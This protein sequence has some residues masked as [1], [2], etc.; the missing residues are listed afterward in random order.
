[1]ETKRR[2]EFQLSR[3][4]SALTR[5]AADEFGDCARCGEPI[6]LKRLMFDTSV[7]LCIDCAEAD[8]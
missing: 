8:P 6:D 4:E 2:R 1:M 3:I 7:V 5:I